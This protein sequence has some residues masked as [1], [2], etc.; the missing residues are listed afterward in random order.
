MKTQKKSNTGLIIFLII[1]GFIF[2]NII[3]DSVDDIDYDYDDEDYIPKEKYNDKTF[4]IIS[5]SENKIL[6]ESL[7]KFA[8]KN[9]ID[10]AITYTDTL[11]VVDK[12]NSGEKYDA[13]LMSNSIWLS[14]LD[15]NTVKTSNLRSTSITPVIF[16]IKESKAN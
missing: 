2:L 7:R 12:L 16:G 9:N 5:S 3:F 6:D 1:F 11:N 4:S 13:I 10:I 8:S 14:M 15:S